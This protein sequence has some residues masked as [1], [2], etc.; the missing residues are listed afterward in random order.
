MRF[1]SRLQGKDLHFQLFGSE[2]PPK[3]CSRRKRRPPPR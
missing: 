3:V 1:Q 2:S